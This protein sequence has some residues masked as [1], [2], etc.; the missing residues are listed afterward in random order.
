MRQNCAD[1]LACVAREEGDGAPGISRVA[2]SQVKLLTIALVRLDNSGVVIVV[3]PC[4]CGTGASASWSA[5]PSSQHDGQQ[6][7]MI[8]VSS[9]R[10]PGDLPS[11][12]C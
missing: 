9:G 12:K 8:S 5:E 6:N 2:G 7:V 10:E 1:M 11:G 3:R 4:F